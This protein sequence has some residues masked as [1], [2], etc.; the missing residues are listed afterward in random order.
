VGQ[1]QAFGGRLTPD[2]A[3]I[4]VQVRDASNRDQM[5]IMDLDGSDFRCTTCNHYAR[6][7]SLEPFADGVRAL[8]NT[9]A[10]SGG[11]LGDVQHAVLECAPSLYGCQ[12]ATSLPVRFPI[13]GLAAGAQNRGVGLHP[14]GT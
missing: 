5:G 7:T 6:A 1:S 13:P 3:H 9:T 12:S 4:V 14:D 10:G 2:N 8:V 11:G